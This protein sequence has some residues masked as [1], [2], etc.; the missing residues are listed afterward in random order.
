MTLIGV[1]AFLALFCAAV[2]AGRRSALAEVRI[3]ELSFSGLRAAA[4]NDAA[5]DT[6]DDQ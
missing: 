5:E 4:I 3:G 1:C 2:I 6:E